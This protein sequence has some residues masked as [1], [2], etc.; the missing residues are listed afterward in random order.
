MAKYA[1]KTPKVTLRIAVLLSKKTT[2]TA[3]TMP[4]PA[5]SHLIKPVDANNLL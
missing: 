2:N 3:F 1:L 4:T 5:G